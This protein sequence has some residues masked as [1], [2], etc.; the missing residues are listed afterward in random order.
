MKVKTRKINWKKV[1][2]Y[3]LQYVLILVS[4]FTYFF[5]SSIFYIPL[6]IVFFMLPIWDKV[7]NLNILAL[8]DY[9]N[10]IKQK[11]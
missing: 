2:D 11:R 5:V 4:Y 8:I 7:I 1:K 6:W 9:R 10:L 3:L